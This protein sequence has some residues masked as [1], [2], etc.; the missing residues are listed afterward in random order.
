M[1]EV[2]IEKTTLTDSEKI[3]W[4]SIVDNLK[5]HYGSFDQAASFPLTLGEVTITDTKGS[6]I[7]AQTQ[8]ELDKLIGTA[9]VVNA[10][11]LSDTCTLPLE[12]NW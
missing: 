11:A 2:E 1:I 9:R 5:K 6:G 10:L 7:V 3:T 4:N 12:P 8:E